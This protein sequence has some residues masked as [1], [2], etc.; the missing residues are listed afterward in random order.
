MRE[1]PT[2]TTYAVWVGVGT[3]LTV[4]HAMVTGVEPVS[5]VRIL[6]LLGLVACIIGLKVLS[7]LLSRIEFEGLTLVCWTRTE[8]S[9][10]EVQA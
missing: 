5:L 2:G 8:L 6:L 1:L 7:Q 3:S 10:G 4:I 9:C